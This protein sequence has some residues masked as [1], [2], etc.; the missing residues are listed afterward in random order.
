MSDLFNFKPKLIT[1][2]ITNEKAKGVDLHNLIINAVKDSQRLLIRPHYDELLVTQE[3]FDDLLKLKTGI[4]SDNYIEDYYLY[5]TGMSVMEV[6]VDKP[7]IEVD[8]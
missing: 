7:I 8:L 4:I 2:D 3:Q 1:L 6:R 5:N